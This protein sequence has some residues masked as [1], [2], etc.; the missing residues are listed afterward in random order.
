M[1]TN[2]LNSLKTDWKDILLKYPELI[3]NIDN[4]Y[5][6]EKSL[7]EPTLKILPPEDKIFNCFKFFNI[8]ELKV[9][10]I[11]QDCYHGRGQANGLC[12]SVPNGIKMPPS[13]RNI[14]KEIK[15]DLGQE[16]LGT[17]FTDLAEQG[18]LFLNTSLSV[19]EKCAGSHIEFWIP[20]TKEIIKDIS[21][22]CNHVIFVLWGNFAKSF[23]PYID[24]NKHYILEAKH[25]SPL[26]A[27]RGGFFGCKHFSKI[28][29]KLEEWNKNPIKWININ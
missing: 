12:F 29:Q 26:S 17:D 20:Y 10:F 9:V 23:K 6:K 15:S 4:N 13:L 21:K 27:N 16:R 7:Y 11:G 5:N 28:N 18:I 19:R 24:I 3:K 1:I 2:Q 8:N 22:T 25:P 14:F